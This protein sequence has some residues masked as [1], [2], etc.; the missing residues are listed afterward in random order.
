MSLTNFGTWCPPY[1]L[2]T[3]NTNLISKLHSSY[4][5]P[6]VNSRKHFSS[7]L[8]NLR[9]T[10]SSHPNF[11][12]YS[13]LCM[14]T[15]FF[16]NFAF[17]HEAYTLHCQQLL[18]VTV[19]HFTNIWESKRWKRK[20]KDDCTWDQ[21]VNATKASFQA[22]QKGYSEIQPTNCLFAAPEVKVDTEMKWKVVVLVFIHFQIKP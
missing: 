13:L 12:V 1:H 17:I 9:T 15:F 11:C 14:A 7:L 10:S 5:W 19:L 3:F 18:A 22:I 2:H 4:T 20:P 16:L 8:N 21:F 6:W